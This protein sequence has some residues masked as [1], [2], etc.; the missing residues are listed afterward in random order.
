MKRVK[1]DFFTGD[2]LSLAPA[3]LGMKLIRAESSGIVRSFVITETEAYRGKEDLACHVSKGRTART[4]IMYHEGGVLYVYLIYGMH[5]MLNI[6]SGKSEEPQA[7]LVRGVHGIS[8]P[9]RVTKALGIDR[10]FNGEDLT[11][12][13]RIWLENSEVRLPYETT[14]R[15]G[16]DYAGPVWKKKLWRFVVTSS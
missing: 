12:S 3:L 5:W 13:S 14:P 11:L 1:K 8:G 15:I 10:S 16:I 9:G 7:V 6:V 2:A 4:E